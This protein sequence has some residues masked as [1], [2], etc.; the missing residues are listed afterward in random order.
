MKAGPDGKFP[1]NGLVDCFL[2]SIKQT[3]VTGLWVGLPTYMFRVC[4]H[5]IVALLT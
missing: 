2:K 1:Y 4:P 5:A 3:G